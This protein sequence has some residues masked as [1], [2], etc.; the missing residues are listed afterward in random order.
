MK[1]SVLTATL[2][3]QIGLENDKNILTCIV[4]SNEVFFKT[5]FFTKNIT[6]S[7][8]DRKTK[9]MCERVL[10]YLFKTNIL[11]DQFHGR[12]SSRARW[13]LEFVNRKISF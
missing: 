7:V 6:L 9:I 13:S 4:N 10:I 3:W 5:T 8:V 1:D 11:A 12:I 2:L